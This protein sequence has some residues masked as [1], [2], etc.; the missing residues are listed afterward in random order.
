VHIAHPRGASLEDIV[1]VLREKGYGLRSVS[2]EEFFALPPQSADQGAAQ[3]ALARLH[4]HPEFRQQ[5]QGMDLF[6]MEGLE[7]ELEAL[8]PLAMPELPNGK[9]LVRR[10]M[11]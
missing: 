3:L 5:F 7:F 4:P 10:C 8:K 6:P 2:A 11:A 9:E 1:A